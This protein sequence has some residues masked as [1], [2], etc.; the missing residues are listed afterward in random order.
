MDNGLAQLEFY[1]I[2]S[3]CCLILLHR[4]FV[5]HV[6]FRELRDVG[7]KK[8]GAVPETEAC[9]FGRGPQEHQKE[10]YCAV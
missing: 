10:Q 1:G 5:D 8:G 6:E 7:G 3:D 2:D 4:R 9:H